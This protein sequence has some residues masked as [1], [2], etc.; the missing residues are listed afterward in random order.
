MDPVQILILKNGD[1]KKLFSRWTF[2]RFKSICR[3]INKSTHTTWDK[4][5][6]IASELGTTALD[7]TSAKWMNGQ[8]FLVAFSPFP[9]GRLSGLI[10]GAARGPARTGARGPVRYRVS[11]FL[12]ARTSVGPARAARARCGRRD[13]AERFHLA[14]GQGEN[15]TGC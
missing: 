11:S 6:A 7:I 5:S 14:D 13:G 2:A 1:I 9:S 15:N 12:L 4:S 10:A 8:T 3:A